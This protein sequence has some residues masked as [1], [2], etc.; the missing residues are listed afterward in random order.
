MKTRCT[1]GLRKVG[2]KNIWVEMTEMYT[3]S[4]TASKI[5]LKKAN[6]N[7]RMAAGCAKAVDAVAQSW[8][9]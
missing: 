1:S 9:N 8:T 5:H 2:E 4:Q 7:P 6:D 3:L